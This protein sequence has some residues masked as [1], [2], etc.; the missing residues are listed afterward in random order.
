MRPGEW[1]LHTRREPPPQGLKVRNRTGTFYKRHE[2]PDLEG[3]STDEVG[4]GL[5]G[6]EGPARVVEL[7]PCTTTFSDIICNGGSGV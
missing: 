5:S 2:A 3:K 6:I 7:T 1:S 4:E